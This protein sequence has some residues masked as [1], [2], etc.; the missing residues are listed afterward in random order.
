MFFFSFNG[1]EGPVDLTRSSQGGPTLPIKKKDVLECVAP[2][3]E[4]SHVYRNI[5]LADAPLVMEVALYSKI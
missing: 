5:K 4:I 1:I 3:P 2:V